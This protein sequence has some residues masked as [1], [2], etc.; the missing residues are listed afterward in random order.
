MA[1]L[2]NSPIDDVRIMLTEHYSQTPLAHL[3]ILSLHPRRPCESGNCQ[4]SGYAGRGCSPITVTGF[5][6]EDHVSNSTNTLHATSKVFS[7]AYK[8]LGGGMY[9]QR[10]KDRRSFGGKTSFPLKTNGGHLVEGDRRSIPDRRLGDIHLELAG[11][12]DCGL[13]ECLT[14]T[15]SY[16]TGTEDY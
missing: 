13:P 15:S 11:A 2:S 14:Y 7:S 8:K 6:L 12:V 16:L 4:R 10:K 9:T 3:A 5:S 1:K